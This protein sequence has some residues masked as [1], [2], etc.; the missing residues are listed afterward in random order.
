MLVSI[1]YVFF[2]FSPCIVFI[3]DNYEKIRSMEEEN[4]KLKE[5]VS[6]LEEIHA[7]QKPESS[8]PTA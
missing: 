3:F 4:A 1:W 7:K 8:N 6:S 5:R 2:I